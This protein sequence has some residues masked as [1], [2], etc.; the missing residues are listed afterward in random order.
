MPQTHFH[1]CPL[2]DAQCGLETITEGEHILSIRGDKSD[3]MSQG[4]ICPKALALQDLHQDPDRLRQP[5]KRVGNTWQTIE[6]ETAYTEIAARLA[7]IQHQHGRDAVALYLGNPLGHNYSGALMVPLLLQALKTRNRFSA[8]SL[9]QL[10]LMLTGLLMFGHQLM[11]PVPDLRRTHYLLMLG[12]NPVVSNGS[13]MGAANIR[14]HLRDLQARRGKL[15]VLDPRYTETAQVADEHHFIRPGTDA[16]LLLAWLHTVFAE[17]LAQLGR[18]K[19]HLRG[20]EHLKAIAAPYSPESV[21]PQIGI[22]AAEIVRLVREFCHA[23]SAV[24]YG[25]LG[26]CVQSFGT[27]STWLITALNIVTGRLDEPGGAMFAQPAIDMTTITRWIGQQGQFGQWH[28]RVRKLPE[29]GQELPAAA[30]AEEILTPGHG[31]IRALITI[32]GNPVLSSPN[33]CQLEQA[34][35]QLE[36]MVS[37]DPY[38][39]ETTAKAHYILPPVSVLERDHAD[40]FLGL[41]AT[42]QAIRYSSAVFDAP[43]GSQHDWQIIQGLSM[44]LFQAQGWPHWLVKTLHKRYPKPHQTFDLFLRSGPYGDRFIPGHPGLN[45]KRLK[46]Q[47]HGLKLGPLTSCLPQRLATSHKQI[48]LA[49]PECVKDLKRLQKTLAQ[50]IPDFVLIGRRHLRSNNS[51]MHNSLP[52]VKGPKACM[53]LMHPADAMRLGVQKGR[54]VRMRSRVG[55]VVV[56]V[57][58]SDKIMPGVVSL[59]HGWG[60]HRPG[61]K[62]QVAQAHAGISM[63][64]LTDENLLDELSGTASLNGI[65]VQ[66]EAVEAV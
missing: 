26:T 12:A 36:L 9:D 48:Q 59:P 21:A 14:G 3:P 34:L 42:H 56:P 5:L 22:D 40:L 32:A 15:V 39:N 50:P 49:P 4:H 11:M 58:V 17:N 44:A 35:D 10:P 2:C 29:F 62:L 47:P 64:D 63:N 61:V 6:W 28:S 46:A 38:C 43:R 1:T 55:E 24:C 41:L 66:L 18:L 33:G 37:V 8:T 25:R 65:P 53:L 45:L 30:L 13:A 52:L 27:L 57:E 20:I 19:P 7:E 23:P 51:W 31:Q 60:H 16:L 54:C